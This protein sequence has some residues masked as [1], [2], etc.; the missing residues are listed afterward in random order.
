LFVSNS[1]W[2]KFTGYFAGAL[3]FLFIAFEAPLSGM[4]I[5]PAR[6]FGS[7]LPAQ[8]W[9][10]FWLYI[11]APITGMQLAAFFYRKGYM[12]FK[13]ECKTM[14]VFMSGD[15]KHNAV[16]KVLCWY[17]KDADGKIIKQLST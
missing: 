15:R 13:N 2:A 6:T 1:R 9:D 5:N 8:N 7:A 14:N 11:I 17:K 16:Y 4:S 12:F 10:S 3:V